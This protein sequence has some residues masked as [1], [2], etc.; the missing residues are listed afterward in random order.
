MTPPIVDAFLTLLPPVN[1]NITPIENGITI[2]TD[3][4]TRSKLIEAGRTVAWDGRYYKSVA[5]LATGSFERPVYPL[6]LEDPQLL[7]GTLY[8][9]SAFSDYVNRY[10]EINWRFSRMANT[11]TTRSDNFEILVVVQSGYGVDENGD[12]RI[13]YRTDDE[14]IVNSEKKARTIYER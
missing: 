9:L 8:P 2:Q 1:P 14:F 12:G 10:Q 11:V 4:Y 7:G 6:T 13:N 3:P 5:D